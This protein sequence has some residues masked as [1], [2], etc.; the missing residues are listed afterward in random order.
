MRISHI[1]LLACCSCFLQGY[2]VWAF[3]DYAP[4]STSIEHSKRR[5]RFLKALQVTPG[6]F[7]WNGHSVQIN[8]A[9]LEHDYEDMYLICFSFK[10]DESIYKEHVLADKEKLRLELPYR[11][12]SHGIYM[13][14]PKM[15]IPL[16]LFKGTY[17]IITHF[18][19]VESPV[20]K[21]YQIEL[22]TGNSTRKQ[23]PTGVT[24]N[25][26]LDG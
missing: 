8:Q 18:V 5:G 12:V 16:L 2:P 3:S 9:W 15:K 4:C 25:V 1:L 7:D 22:Y 21:T 26:Q 17:G 10:V 20:P 14:L 24:L 6:Y 19:Q 13:T 23:T 11:K